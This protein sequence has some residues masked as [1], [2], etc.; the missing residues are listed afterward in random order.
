MSTPATPYQKSATDGVWQR[1][2]IEAF[3][4]SDGD[5]VEDRIQE[6]LKNAKDKSVLSSELRTHITDWPSNYHLS[7]QRA[8]ILRPLKHL[9]EGSILEI[10]SGCGAITRYLGES[11][12]Q[13]VALEGSRRRAHITRVRTQELSNVEVICDEFSKF[14]TDQR[15]DA[16]TLIGVLEYASMFVSGKNPAQ[17]MLAKAQSLLKENGVLIVAIENQLGLKYFAGS[18]EDHLNAAMLGLEDQYIENGVRTYGKRALEQLIESSGFQDIECLYPFPDYKMPTSIVSQQGFENPHFDVKPF[19]TT[20][21]SKDPQIPVQ[22]N[23][24]LERV[25]GVIADN[26]LGPDLS[27]SFLFVARLEDQNHSPTGCLAWHYSTGRKQEFCKETLFEASSSSVNPINITRRLL[28]SEGKKQQ[29]GTG[30]FQHAHEESVPYR[31]K[32][33]LNSLLIDIVTRTNWHSDE[34]GKFIFTY[35]AHLERITGENLISNEKIDWNS[36]IPGN[37]FDCI[38]QNMFVYDGTPESN[39]AFDL[40]WTIDKRID[41][42]QMVFR[43]LWHTIGALSLIGAGREHASVSMLT[44]IKVALMA[45]GKEL[46]DEEVHSALRQELDFLE[47][48]TGERRDVEKTYQWLSTTPL[49]NANSHEFMHHSREQELSDLKQHCER[50]ETIRSDLTKQCGDLEQHARN[51]TERSNVFEARSNKLM[52]QYGEV[53]AHAGIRSEDNEEPNEGAVKAVLDQLNGAK[54][55]Q[56]ESLNAHKAIRTLAQ[57]SVHQYLSKR[58]PRTMLK[59]FREYRSLELDRLNTGKS[60]ALSFAG[61]VYNIAQSLLHTRP[62]LIINHQ[63]D[64][65]GVALQLLKQSCHWPIPLIWNVQGQEGDDTALIR[66]AARSIGLPVH[67]NTSIEEIDHKGQA[68]VGSL[69]LASTETST[70]T[71]V[72]PRLEPELVR[73]GYLAMISNPKLSAVY[74]GVGPQEAKLPETSKCF[75]SMFRRSALA[76]FD[77]ESLVQ[78]RRITHSTL[79]QEIT[80][81]RARMKPQGLEVAVL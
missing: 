77:N 56:Q 33:T 43:S 34:I 3:A 1:P 29:T 58:T 32:P 45:A 36:A 20:T 37:Y 55:W 81:L 13:V 30:Q 73:L 27:N 54:I 6:I 51:L 28:S 71:D 49:K 78:E 47:A 69:R 40:E 12:A 76:T 25:W 60:S 44:L 11:A 62:H 9:V 4:Y 66:H 48:V 75:L 80:T 10:G 35:V 65:D 67:L 61:D 17:R 22:T 42:Y 15:F 23:F 16:I 79:A 68:F 59:Q 7:A 31:L 5:E 21:V 14:E 52:R 46:T 8:N 63:L 70:S 24:R 57:S 72:W 38:P 50:L 18:P 2:S 26:E 74:V 19:L 64:S 41:V 39:G 53:L